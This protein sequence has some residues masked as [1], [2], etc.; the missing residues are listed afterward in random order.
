VRKSTDAAAAAQA[1]TEANIARTKAEAA[2]KL[3]ALE[4]RIRSRAAKAAA[5]EAAIRVKEDAANKKEAEVK[6]R[7]E[8]QQKPQ[9]QKGAPMVEPKVEFEVPQ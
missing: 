3:S 4:K 6:A 9:F 8:R 1:K 7:I 2:A 5:L